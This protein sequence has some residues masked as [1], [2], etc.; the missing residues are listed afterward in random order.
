[1]M[2]D[3]RGGGACGCC[4]RAPA[5][6]GR[7]RVREMMS[8]LRATAWSTLGA[9]AGAAR[10]QCCAA[11]TE[12]A[13]KTA[14]RP[15]Q[16]GTDAQSGRFG[17]A[18]APDAWVIA[19][20][21]VADASGRLHGAHGMHS[22]CA[23]GASMRRL[24]RQEGQG[25]AMRSASCDPPSSTAS[26]V[27]PGGTTVRG[28][29]GRCLAFIRQGA[30]RAGG[31]ARHRPP[32]PCAAGHRARQRAGDGGMRRRGLPCVEGAGRLVGCC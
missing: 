24:S 18:H 32:A 4:L 11:L 28:A 9:G 29:P 6:V 14:I 26:A 7:W 13:V 16:V 21:T 5:I 12:A 27:L 19:A 23:L 17:M 3:E 20:D 31:A 1:M 15:R 2:R 10:A 8:A 30:R 25:A 22:M